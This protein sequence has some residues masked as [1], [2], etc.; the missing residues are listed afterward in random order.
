[1]TDVPRLARR[2]PRSLTAE[3]LASLDVTTPAEQARV[4]AWIV[5]EDGVEELVTGQA[6]AWT[7][8]AVKVR[9]GT[10]P[11]ALEV[12]VWAGAVQRL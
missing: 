10:P 11:H 7:R 1:M 5:W 12:W 9:W 8:R 2:Q 4:R 3:Q 6:I